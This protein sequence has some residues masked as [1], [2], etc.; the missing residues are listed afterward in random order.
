MNEASVSDHWGLSRFGVRFR[1]EDVAR[2][3]AA[4]R[5][6]GA[7]TVDLFSILDRPPA[8]ELLMDDG[9]HFTLAGQKRLALEVIGGWSNVS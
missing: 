2:V 9:L 5:G 6:I 4:V 3:A 1:N 8:P 7:P